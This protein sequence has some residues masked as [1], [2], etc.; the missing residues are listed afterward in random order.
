MFALVLINLKEANLFIKQHHRHHPPARGCK[1]SLGV[2]FNGVLC[3]VALVGRP[4]ARK[5]QDKHTL[6]V[7]RLCTDGTKHACSLLYGASW[8][9]AKAIGCSRLIT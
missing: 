5:A 8:R 3:G 1:F 6:E 2:E 9:A 4:V 7:T